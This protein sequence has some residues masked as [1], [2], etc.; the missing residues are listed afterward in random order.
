[1]NPDQ[2]ELDRWT[3]D[4]LEYLR[5]EYPK[6]NK[7]SVVVDIGAFHCDWSIEISKKYNNPKIYAFEASE[8]FYNISKS[9]IEEFKNIKLFKKGIGKKFEKSILKIGVADGVST[10][11]FIESD[12]QEEVTIVPVTQLFD[13]H[14]I[15]NIDLM[16][17]NI[18]GSEYD[19]LECLIENNLVTKIKN[20]QVQFHRLGDNY[21][22]RFEN[23]KK[24]LSKTH[25]LTY[26]CI[27]IW[28]N[29]ELIE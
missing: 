27:F 13:L 6:L 1:M 28:E 15:K 7:D 29:W 9:K 20:I 25:K 19:V 8:K 14:K 18:E 3:N 12:E 22:E 2:A 21:M 23:I 16:K 10:S 5:Y 24:E 17:I 26:E 11:L 4:K